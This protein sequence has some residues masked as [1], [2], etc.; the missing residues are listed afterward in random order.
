MANVKVTLSG[1]FHNAADITIQLP[2]KVA[3]D[4]K[5]GHVSITDYHVLSR[6]QRIKLDR[7]FCGI[8]GCKCGGVAR[9]DIQF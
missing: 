4:L 3:E 6:S 2:A 1:G 8:R 7:H 9:A 5:N